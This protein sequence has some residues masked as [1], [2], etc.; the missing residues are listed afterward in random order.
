MNMEAFK[1]DDAFQRSSNGA[2]TP[3]SQVN[4]KLA[5]S[6]MQVALSYDEF[7]DRLMCSTSND[8]PRPLED[9]IVDRLWLDID[10]RYRFRPPRDFFY[11]VVRDLARRNSFHP[12]RD[13]LD[14][15]AWDG[16]SRV[17]GWLS[18]YGGAEKSDYV[19]AVGALV[20]IAAV[21]RIRKPG[22]KFDEM[23]VLESPQGSAQKSSAIATLCPNQEWFSDDLPLSSDSQEVIER[24]SGH[25]LVE[26]SEMSGMRGRDVE[27]LKAFL[28]RPVDKARMAYDR[29][30]TVRPRH[31][32][33][34]GTTNN[35]K[36]LRDSTG[37]RRFWPVKVPYF[38]LE[39]LRRDR[40]QLWAEA[41]AR[42]ALGGSIRLAKD[43]WPAAALEQEARRVVDPIEETILEAIGDA[44]GK[45]PTSKVWGLLGLG[46]PSRRT[47]DLNTR[48][49]QVMHMA[50]FERKK[51]RDAKTGK[52]VFHYARGTKEERE[53]NIDIDSDM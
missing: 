31:F 45:I 41:A 48:L 5:L 27:H 50:G 52:S 7:S 19:K 49:G 14:G 16:I 43:L 12:V 39:A 13:Y 3:A 23:L 18:C 17:D 15:L 51:L 37:A 30:V 4:I 53:K 28:A 44:N 46:D 21:R 25:W 9:S 34:I 8:A 20:L 33:L 29:I 2:V 10:D 38:D 6:L 35:D 26:A 1:E 40:D 47:Q 42:E 24:T 36:Y 22:A 11:I 32:V